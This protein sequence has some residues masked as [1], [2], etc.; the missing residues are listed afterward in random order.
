MI[1]IGPHQFPTKDA[2]KAFIRSVLARYAPGDLVDGEDHETLMELTLRHPRADE[3]V[4][5]GIDRFRVVLGPYGKSRAYEILRTDGTGTDISFP[6]CVDGDPPHRTLVLRSLR[7]VVEPDVNALRQRLF[8]ALIGEDGRLPCEL[9]GARLL[10]TEGHLDHI[11]PNT[12]LRLATLFLTAHGLDIDT[13]PLAPSRDGEIGR[14]LLDPDLGAQ[15][16]AFHARI[17]RF[18]FIAAREN[19]SLGGRIQDEGHQI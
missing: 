1:E 5:S 10:P 4:G 7:L 13:V 17:A 11:A 14:R 2:A 3:K 8:R 18:R 19:L 12:F 9:T 6:K 15:F 16:R